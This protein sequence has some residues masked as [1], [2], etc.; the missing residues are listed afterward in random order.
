MATADQIFRTRSPLRSAWRGGYGA[1][2]SI[3]ALFAAALLCL[4]ATGCSSNGSHSSSHASSRHLAGN[5]PAQSV[6]SSHKGQA[7]GYLAGDADADEDDKGNKR[8]NL[9]VSGNDTFVPASDGKEAGRTDKQRIATLIKRYYLA[10]AAGDG[11]RGCALLDPALTKELAAGQERPGEVASKACAAAVS[12]IFRQ[13][14]Q[15]LAS[16]DVATMSV[17]E[18]RVKGDVAAA[19]VGFRTMPVGRIHLKRDRGHWK[20]DA[21][22]DTGLT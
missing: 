18:V 17:I 9:E 12:Q 8:Y 13:Q 21:L 16:D 20:V 19:L 10:A 1:P 15:L 2:K 5:A 4:S 7:G 6:K 11:A 22:F 3:P 14:H